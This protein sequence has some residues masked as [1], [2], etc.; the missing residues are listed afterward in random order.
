MAARQ[1][2]SG[3]PGARIGGIAQGSNDMTEDKLEVR[4]VPFPFQWQHCPFCWRPIHEQQ[5]ITVTHHRFRYENDC[6]CLAYALGEVEPDGSYYWEVIEFNNRCTT[7][8]SLLN[9]EH[10]QQPWST[11]DTPANL[12][13]PNLSWLYEEAQILINSYG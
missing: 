9:W 1:L 10:W 4:L 7:E 6:T 13:V 2:E 12:T 3:Q 5:I 8:P 11:I